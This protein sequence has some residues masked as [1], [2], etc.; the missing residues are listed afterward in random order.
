MAQFVA[1]RCHT[2][3]AIQVWECIE[4]NGKD[5]SEEVRKLNIGDFLNWK[6]HDSFE[7]AFERLLRDLRTE[8]STVGKGP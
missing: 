3:D 4:A 2:P 7:R 5:L 1:N 6:D 8:E